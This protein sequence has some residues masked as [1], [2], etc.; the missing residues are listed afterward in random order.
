MASTYS[1]N[2][3]IELIGSGEQSGVWGDTTNTNLGTLLE[4]AI[5]GFATQAVTDGAATVLT[6]PDGE[7][8]V[9]RNYV[10]ELTGALTANRDVEVPA[11]DKPYTF[12]N[13][14]T[15][16]F[17]VTVK[18]SGGTGVAVA[19]G[20]KAIVYANS[21]DVIEVANA[22]VTEAG[23]QTLTNKTLTDPTIIGGSWT[24]TSP[25]SISVNSTSDALR[26]TQTGTGDAF[27]VEDSASTDSTPFVISASGQVI[28][29]ATQAYTPVAGRFAPIEVN[30]TATTTDAAT[31][32]KWGNTVNSLDMTF[33]RS[34]GAVGVQTVVNSGDVISNL[35]F[36]GSDGTSFVPAA[37]IIAAVDGTP[38]TNDMP[39]RLQFA[40]TADGAASP[41]E[42]MRIDS[43]GQVGIGSTPVVGRTFTLGKAI[44][45]ATTAYSQFN[46]G[47]IQSDVTTTAYFSFTIPSTAAASFTL[48][49]LVHY[50]A[51]QGAI[52]AGSSV[53]NQYGFQAANTIVGA[54]N[55]F[56][57][58]GDV[59]AGVTRTI[60]NV[61]LTSNVVT[62]TTSVAHG[63]LAG[64]SV[65]VAATTNTAINGTYTIASV[66]TTTT[67]TY[68]RTS[69]DIASTADTGTTVIVGRYNFYANGTA[70]NYFAGKVGIGNIT[71][72]ASAA[73]DVTS[74]TAGVLFPR[75][76][77][78]QRDAI[79]S[80]ANG[81]VLYNT[82][83]DKLQVRAGG[84]WVDLH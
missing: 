72:A 76:T 30:A 64:Q 4:Q 49:N 63:Y 31:F 12:F 18:V 26:V 56:A 82:T 44:T 66:P 3:K 84:A 34:R 73:L 14:T 83:T 41:T 45:G 50:A 59:P 67:L 77:G 9:G 22:P 2:L 70:P 33:S 17:S 37:L 62:V 11:V 71:P 10:I 81:L 25:S 53:T 5:A 29:G 23:T 7:S 47:T 20:K 40:T 65:T 74:T 1:P 38:G 68:A 57:F 78:T 75:M 28:I 60:T 51:A 15:G 8:S 58:R 79:A 32:T 69:A 13:N 19:N 36:R 54:A 61:E 6:I 16:G 48:N 52:G 43:A 55:N 35:S 42:R 24:A 46:G 80:P 27:V 21:I 39:G